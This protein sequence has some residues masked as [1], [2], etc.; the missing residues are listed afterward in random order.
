MLKANKTRHFST[1]NT[2]FSSPNP[3][4]F[5]KTLKKTSSIYHQNNFQELTPTT[6][7]TSSLKT[8]PNSS[9]YLKLDHRCLSTVNLQHIQENLQI[10][11]LNECKLKDFPPNFLV[12]LTN[13]K[14]LFLDSNY[15]SY[16][17][18]VLMES[19]SLEIFSIK[20]NNIEVLPENFY[21]WG[22]SLLSLD[23]SYNSIDKLE[24]NLCDLK[25]LRKLMLNNNNFIKLPVSL[26]KIQFLDEIGLDWFKYTFPPNP[27]IISGET[28]KYFLKFCEYSQKQGKNHLDFLEVVTAFSAQKVELSK[29]IT[30]KRTLIQRAAF[31]NDVGV[32]RSLI[33]LIPQCINE[34]DSENYTALFLSILEENYT[35]TRILLFSGA[36]PSI[37]VGMLGGCI[38][39]A[40]VKKEVFLLQELLKKGGDPN[41]VD[42]QGNT[43]L[44]LLFSTFSNNV[45]KGEKIANILMEFHANP[46]VKNKEMWDCLHLAV[47]GQQL[48]AVR[49]A[50]QYNQR[51]NREIF[52][53]NAVGGEINMTLLH[54]AAYDG[55]REILKFLID[56][57][58]DYLIAD[59]LERLPKNLCVN[60]NYL[61]KLLKIREK[62]DMRKFRR[63]NK[64]IKNNMNKININ[65]LTIQVDEEDVNENC[66]Q[67]VN[68][69]MT[70]TTHA[71]KINFF[72][73]KAKYFS[74]QNKIN[75]KVFRENENFDENCSVDI[76]E[77]SERRHK[78]IRVILKS[79]NNIEKIDQYQAIRTS[80]TKK[81]LSFKSEKCVNYAEKIVS[82][83]TFSL[84]N[85]ENI[86][87]T[88]NSNNIKLKE[89]LKKRFSKD[90]NNSGLESLN[91]L[92]NLQK[93]QKFYL[94]KYEQEI[95]VLSSFMKQDP[96]N[97][98]EKQK[99]I[100]KIIAFSNKQEF[101]HIQ[102]EKALLNWF[103]EKIIKIYKK[104]NEFE[105]LRN[106]LLIMQNIL[107]TTFENIKENLLFYKQ[108]INQPHMNR[109]IIYEFF[110]ILLIL[111]SSKSLYK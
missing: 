70:S 54:L 83:K 51:E 13:L 41:A 105:Y 57:G 1:Q 81:S 56:I 79:P 63:Q 94:K 12:H 75:P 101:V 22:E 67:N 21:K 109:L 27:F 72:S 53:F 25:N 29:Q 73:N 30:K 106:G 34:T 74:N 64:R 23:V 36:D 55:N 90:L 28:T 11:I 100:N 104:F 102:C 82:L 38:H 14:Q 45:Q 59:N 107:F 78:T 69:I 15:F 4:S 52:D 62:N 92:I 98:T 9:N 37:G 80:I 66:E 97:G 86:I 50:F 2:I 85:L 46:A 76:E 19:S 26:Y 103:S 68:T 49:W 10:L 65:N 6:K 42:Q 87:N 33:S 43:P 32:L 7:T 77:S 44:N 93:K 91:N 24:N 84:Q 58:C 88:L 8:H 16:I 31:E 110:N 18:K 5:D 35:A 95:N 111:N 61:L 99:E 71:N 3:K 96:K 40:V 60:D 39:L 48:E 47:K 17:P 108:N 89:E 20:H